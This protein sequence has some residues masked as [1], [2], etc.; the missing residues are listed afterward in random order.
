MKTHLKYR[1]RVH[2]CR[3]TVRNQPAET[4]ISSIKPLDDDAIRKK[5]Y[6]YFSKEVF[7][8]LKWSVMPVASNHKKNKS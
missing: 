8:M 6:G 2:F 4:I 3:V 1:Y 7:E 5:F